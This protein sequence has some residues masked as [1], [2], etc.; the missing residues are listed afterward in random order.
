LKA[1][2]F[3]Q[4]TQQPSSDANSCATSAISLLMGTTRALRLCA[5]IGHAHYKKLLK[6]PE[7]DPLTAAA[8]AAAAT[9]S[10]QLLLQVFSK[11]PG[12]SSFA[13]QAALRVLTRGQLA[14]VTI[15]APDDDR[16]VT[17]AVADIC[18]PAAVAVSWLSMQQQQQQQQQ[19]AS[20]CQQDSSVA[21]AAAAAAAEAAAEAATVASEAAVRPAT[22][23]ALLAA[24]RAAAFTLLVSAFKAQAAAM[25]LHDENEQNY[26]RS[27]DAA[28]SELVPLNVQKIF[29]RGVELA[30]I[31]LH[32]ICRRAAWQVGNAVGSVSSSGGASSSSSS[33]GASSGIS[34]ST[35]PLYG[36]LQVLLTLVV[37]HSLQVVGQ[38]VESA[39]T[40][41]YKAGRGKEVEQL[42]MECV[43][44]LGCDV[45]VAPGVQV[46]TPECIAA[47][48]LWLQA[49]VQQ[50]STPPSPAAGSKA[51]GSVTGADVPPAAATVAAT[52]AAGLLLQLPPQL[53]QWLQQQCRYFSKHQESLCWKD[54]RR[55]LKSQGL[56]KPQQQQ[57]QQQQHQQQE[58]RDTQQLDVQQQQQQHDQSKKKKKKFNKATQPQRGLQLVQLAQRLQQLGAAVI[59]QLPQPHCCNNPGCR[60]LGGLSERQLVSGRGSRCS[61]CKVARFCSRECQA[62]HW[63]APAGHKA[64]CKRLQAAGSSG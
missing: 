34:S 26:G 5:G 4:Q 40:A 64:V 56:V 17:Q 2:A 28:D 57:H 31:T 62:E 33:S 1:A 63:G 10:S 59:S 29:G 48:L 60:N 35:G 41:A 14:G 9:G 8:A 61:G 12:T 53:Q 19:Q 44:T 55:Y 37:A 49:A 46:C 22:I 3:L 16:L 25:P 42:L 50:M 45:A 18:R 21:A 52:G 47:G 51:A 38:Y 13:M 39:M 30:C 36:E 23:A 27:D 20:T 7:T 32:G 54:Y 11:Q 15:P 6:E 58:Q 43:I 24:D